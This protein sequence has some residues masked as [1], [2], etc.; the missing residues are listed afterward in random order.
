M[1]PAWYTSS[2]KNV[3]CRL[4]SP[5][6]TD[7]RNQLQKWTL[8]S[9]SQG[10]EA[11]VDYCYFIGSKL[12][13]FCCPSCTRLWHSS[14]LSKTFSD[15]LGVYSSLAPVSSNS[16][17]VSFL[18][19]KSPVVLS[20]FTTLWI[21]CPLETLSSWNLRQNFHWHFLADLYFTQVSHIHFALKYTAPWHTTLLTNCDGEQMVN[22]IG[23]CCLLL[24]NYKQTPMHELDCLLWNT[25]SS[26][27]PQL[28][29][30]LHSKR[31]RS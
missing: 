10:C 3:N 12:Q 14:L 24:I 9:G 18:S 13:Q 28:I 29:T 23:N 5:S 17:S 6:V 22:G 2:E 15:F 4:I 25:M 16:Y 30:S 27:G 8:L 1:T 20:L 19:I 31:Y 26:S 21:V 11:C 7:C